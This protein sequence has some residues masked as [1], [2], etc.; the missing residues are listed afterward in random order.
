MVCREVQLATG[1]D[2]GQDRTVGP[3]VG[4]GLVRRNTGAT[5]TCVE[6]YSVDE[7]DTKGEDEDEEEDEDEDKDDED[8]EDEDDEDEDEDEDKDGR[9]EVE[10]VVLE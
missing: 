9:D 2:C 10:V 5:R 7:E 3:V 6:R 8:D 4:A 1:E